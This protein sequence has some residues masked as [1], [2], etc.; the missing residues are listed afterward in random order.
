M[1]IGFGCVNL[2]GASSGTAWRDQLALVHAAIDSGVTIFDTADV[3][4]SGASERILGRAVRGRRGEITLSTKGG[5]IFRPRSVFE[6][7]ARH[8]VGRFRSSIGREY[9]RGIGRTR[10]A[11][12]RASYQAQ[13]FSTTRLRIALQASLRRLGTDYV[14][15]YQIHGPPEIL[16]QLFDE[17]GDLRRAGTVRRFG[18]GAESVSAAAMWARA[19]SV[20]MLQLPFGI[21][22]PEAATKVF[23]PARANNT[24][25]WARGV[26]GGG[27]L[28]AASRDLDV[29]AHHPKSG[30]IAA[31]LR[32]AQ[33]AGMAVDELAIR[34]VRRH[35]DVAT[36]IVGIS[37]I[38][39]LHRNLVLATLPPLPDDVAAAL[40]RVVGGHAVDEGEPR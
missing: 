10:G 21:L 26:L 18:V 2:G 33:D 7:R 29:V 38:E 9:P 22:D 12:T 39:H 37:S 40:A 25:I 8:V 34:W 14:D 36:V 1:E 6:Q 3:Y 20:D 32:I 4:G 27:L 16:P 23:G 19:V 17:L 5:Y 11:G 24:E 15:V 31:V 35:H 30:V 28:A 13:D